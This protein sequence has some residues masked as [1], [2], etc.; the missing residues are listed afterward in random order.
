[1]QEEKVIGAICDANVLI[2]YV[3]ADADLI[4]E[5]VGFW[6]RVY[7][8]DIVLLEVRQISPERAK[9]LGLEIM[10]TPLSLPEVKSL[11]LQDRAC[12]YFVIENG[13]TCIA[14]DRQLRNECT[15][16]SG[17][18]IWGLEMLLKLV[19]AGMITKGRAREAGIK[20]KADNPLILEA[21]LTEFLQQLDKVEN[22]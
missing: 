11:S 8:P 6:G 22:G 5:L 20:I 13:W 15:R 7:V 17:K 14:N 1:M 16:N 2:D 19:S 10:E 12:L 3:K 18:V 9:S 4:K 21:T